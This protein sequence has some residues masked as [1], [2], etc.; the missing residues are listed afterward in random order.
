MDMPWL[1]VGLGDPWWLLL[2]YVAGI[3]A[4]AVGLPPL[5]GF[6][7]AGFLLNAFGAE[8]GEL[9]QQISDLGVTLLLFTIGLKIDL[10][11]LTRF[12]VW[13][14]GL[15]HMVGIVVIFSGLLMLLAI[16]GVG[17]FAGL[18]RGE[19]VTLAFAFSFSSTVFAIK[20]LEDQGAL[21]TRNG[22]VAIG[23]L[24]LQDIVAVV[25]LALSQGKPPS[26]WAILLLLLIPLRPVLKKIMRRSGHGALLRLFGVTAALVGAGL[27]VLVGI[28]GDLGALALG[29][30]LAGG[31]KADELN[32]SLMGIKDLFLLGF[33]LEIGLDALPTVNGLVAAGIILL[34][35]PLK[36]LLFFVLLSWGKLRSRTAWQASLDLT[37]FSE[38]GLIV[39]ATA[40]E[41]GRMDDDWLAIL[42]VTIAA[43]FAIVAPVAERGDD[44]FA[45][46][47][48][49]LKGLER[50]QR[51]PGDE[52]LQLHQVQL[53]VFGM[54][55]MGSRAYEAVAP[56]FGGRVLGVDV[57][58]G[59]VA[60]HAAQGDR[61]VVG[62]ATD[63]DFWTRARGLVEGLEWVL[64]TMSSTEA[65]IAAVQRL[66][67]RGYTGRIAATSVYPDDARR[68]RE[69]GVD[70]AFDVYAEAGAGFAG[71][72]RTKIREEGLV[73]DTD[74]TE[75][76]SDETR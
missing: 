54:G 67:D 74:P 33:F 35:L 3:L 26:P 29:M 38:F 32:K 61:V 64:L 44:L 34:L 57:D 39:A 76:D 66:R 17:A 45:K 23:I 5:V 46:Y 30:L 49:R 47:G 21:T 70:F 71:D 15:I 42:A 48:S 8:S 13:G 7:A 65:N 11:S 40:V 6:L 63:P 1:S 43:S 19:A 37:S 72:L 31:G 55:R 12:E 56:D 52:D 22:R 10:R 50:R 60:E 41:S 16:S 51:L 75:E 53:I 18:G 28:K 69:L 36:S 24:V 9:L 4:R 27:F 59:R 2:A 68:L 73:D 58:E 25:Y 62:D 14:V 20:V